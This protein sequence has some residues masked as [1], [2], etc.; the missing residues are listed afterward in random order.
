MSSESPLLDDNA[1]YRTLLES[2]KA[3]PWKIDWATKQFAYIGPQ[4][5]TLL[6]WKADSWVSV[7]DWAMRMHPEDRDYVVNFCVTQSQ[8]GVDHEADYRA[9]TKENGYVWIRDVVHVV[10][11]DRGE[12]EALIGFM[13]DITERKK[14]EEKLLTLQKELEALSF[15]DGLTNI[16]NRRRFDSGFELEWERARSERQPLSMLLFDVDFFKQYNDLYGHTQGDQCLVD[17]AQTLSLALDGPRDLV[18]R[19]GGEEFVVLLPEAD[20]EVA[21]K[22][23]E[24]CQRLLQKKAIVHALSPH[25]RRVTVSIGAGTVVPDG[26]IDRAGFIEAVDQQLYAAKK[27]GRDRIEHMQL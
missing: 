3:I 27:N 23:A 13:F 26:K 25:G 6:G 2:T 20:A 9:L 19:Y 10:R 22:V 17:I 12:V 14:T 5:E 8:A 1:V 11:N 16:A 7:E 4:I 21:R 15:K 24:R 18:A